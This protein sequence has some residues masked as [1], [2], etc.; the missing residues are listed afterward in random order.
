MQLEQAGNASSGW[1][2]RSQAS[3]IPL[4]IRHR[5]AVAQ[6]HLRRSLSWGFNVQ[7]LGW[8]C[9]CLQTS[10]PPGLC[11]LDMSSR[12]DAATAW[13]SLRYLYLWVFRSRSN[14]LIRQSKMPKD[15]PVCL[16]GIFP[17][18]AGHLLQSERLRTEFLQL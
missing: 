11:T 4:Y 3:K 10:D 13:T 12:F 9:C 18:H 17:Q 1:P 14:V 5:G 7:G 2:I 8:F 15:R 6:V 16:K